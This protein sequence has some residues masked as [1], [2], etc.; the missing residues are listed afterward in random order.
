MLINDHIFGFLRKDGLFCVFG[1]QNLPKIIF[2]SSKITYF[3]RHKVYFLAAENN[4]Y[5]SNRMWL[6]KRI[7]F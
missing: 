1:G 2:M 3:W 5:F 6:V 4:F 7:I